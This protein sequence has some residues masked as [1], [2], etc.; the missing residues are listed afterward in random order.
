MRKAFHR[1]CDAKSAAFSG[2]ETIKL[3]ENDVNI[4][5]NRTST[6]KWSIFKRQNTL[7]TSIIIQLK[8]YRVI[9]SRSLKWV[10]NWRIYATPHIHVDTCERC[11]L[12]TASFV[13]IKLCFASFVSM[14][15]EVRSVTRIINWQLCT[16]NANW[17]GNRRLRIYLLAC[18]YPFIRCVSWTHTA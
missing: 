7:K 13:V 18:L 11:S 10:R 5:F 1:W 16:V 2:R 9:I 14:W 4:I 12:S 17:N 8:L 3:P 15:H 6:S